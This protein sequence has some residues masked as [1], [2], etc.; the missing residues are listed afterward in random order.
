MVKVISL[1]NDA[2]E[3]LKVRKLPGKSFSDVVVEMTEN[4][5]KKPSIMDF[6]GALKDDKE[7]VEILRKVVADRKNIKLRHV[8]F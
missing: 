4:K 6:F 2:Y 5:E 3:R 8:K 1:S 7:T